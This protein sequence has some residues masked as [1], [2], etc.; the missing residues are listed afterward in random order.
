LTSPLPIAHNC[1]ILDACCIINLYASCRMSDILTSIA[2][3]VTVAAYVQDHEARAVYTADGSGARE[4]IDL[5]PFIN[6]GLLRVVDIETTAENANYLDFAA[7]LGDDGEAI[8]GAIAAERDWA[9]GTDDGAA[10]RFFTQR[11][12]TLQLV[13]SLELLKHWADTT[14]VPEVE[15]GTALRLVRICGRYQ[16]KVRHA[17]YAWWQANYARR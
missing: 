2:R 9:I 3:S 8:T 7:T 12:P 11:C 17:L 15:L 6:Q 4:V 13:S 10:I 5:N 1:L 16:P 14:S